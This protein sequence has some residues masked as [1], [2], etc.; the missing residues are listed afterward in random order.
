MS[1]AA[2]AGPD[3]SVCLL[4]RHRRAGMD[5]ST[6]NSGV[7]HA[8]IYYGSG[9]LKARLC[10]QGRQ[11]LYAYC[12]DRGVPHR[13]CGKLIVATEA[14][15]ISKMEAILKQGLANGIEGL[16]M[17]EAAAARVMEPALHCVAAVHSPA[18]GIVDSH[19][20]M[21]ALEGDLE[22][23]GGTVVFRS[24]VVFTPYVGREALRPILAAVLEVLR[25][26]KRTARRL[27]LARQE[28]PQ[29]ILLDVAMPGLGGIE[30]ARRANP[31][32]RLPH[33]CRRTL[34]RLDRSESAGLF[35]PRL[36]L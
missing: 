22:N 4:E 1:R 28:S 5:T 12:A 6:H 31:D 16:T 17:I 35:V 27:T 26:G 23:A 33:R 30:A 36:L 21:L 11:A 10:V 7:I 13:N 29:V 15:E 24:P 20:F 25:A 19:A 3:R 18:T 32:S 14:A 34:V 8:G 2:T 9:T